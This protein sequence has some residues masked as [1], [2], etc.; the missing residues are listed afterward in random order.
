MNHYRKIAVLLLAVLLVSLA[1]PAY[2]LDTYYFAVAGS[3]RWSLSGETEIRFKMNEQFFRDYQ[4]NYEQSLGWIPWEGNLLYTEEFAIP[5]TPEQAEIVSADPKACELTVLFH[6]PGRYY[7]TSSTRIYILD[8]A[9]ETL[10]AVGAKLNEAV[11]TCRGRNEK[12]TASRIVNWIAKKIKYDGGSTDYPE[13]GQYEDTIGV[14]TSGK[15]ICV[16]YTALYELLAE[17]CG[18]RTFKVDV[19]VN[20][21]NTWHIITLNRLDGE[22]S[23]TDA[24]WE[25]GGNSS[26]NTYFAMDKNKMNRYYS[27]PDYNEFYPKWFSDPER[28]T[29]LNSLL[30]F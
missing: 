27:I 24:T 2:A 10:A 16:G 23:F 15:A 6:Q 5:V 7:I 3:P 8:P 4:N 29:E 9:N 25:D 19:E 21:N 26:R 13:R 12:E 30:D 18:I 22:W 20:E 14:L 17:A 28:T 1:A 11:E